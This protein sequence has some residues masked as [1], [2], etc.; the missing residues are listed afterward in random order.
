MVAKLVGYLESTR[1]VLQRYPESDL[2]VPSRYRPVP[3]LFIGTSNWT[4]PFHLSRP[5]REEPDNPY[6]HELR[7]QMYLKR[8]V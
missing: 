4:K 5:D 1:I 2:S 8:F 3:S 7:G 6:F